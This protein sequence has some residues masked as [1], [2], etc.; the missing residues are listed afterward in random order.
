MYRLP[1]NSRQVGLLINAVVSRRT[2]NVTLKFIQQNMLVYFRKSFECNTVTP[3]FDIYWLL[4]TFRN[5]VYQFAYLLVCCFKLN[6]LLCYIA[7]TFT[8]LLNWPKISQA[9]RLK[10]RPVVA[11]NWVKRLE[12]RLGFDLIWT[13]Q[14][15]VWQPSLIS[16]IH[17]FICSYPTIKFHDAK[18]A[19]AK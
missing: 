16:L 14:P 1:H 9:E 2:L 3:R 19:N 6:N 10:W 7:I 5:Y 8:L 13:Q 15:I 17:S 18:H 12:N 11:L 4:Y